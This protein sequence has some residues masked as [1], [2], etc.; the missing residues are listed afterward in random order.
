VATPLV[1]R[2]RRAQP[3]PPSAY[4]RSMS[5]RRRPASTA[6]GHPRATARCRL[7]RSGPGRPQ[8][9]GAR[10]GFGRLMPPGTATSGRR[11]AYGRPR[12]LAA[13][14]G[15]SRLRYPRI[16]LVVLGGR[17][18]E[19]TPVPRVVAHARAPRPACHAQESRPVNFDAIERVVR[20]RR[21]NLSAQ[22]E[23]HSKR[24]PSGRSGDRGAQRTQGIDDAQ[25][26]HSAMRRAVS[27]TRR[28][29]DIPLEEEDHRPK[30]APRPSQAPTAKRGATA[31]QPASP[32][33]RYPDA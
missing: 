13:A 26:A 9:Q 11:R 4:L 16:R 7:R 32:P 2:R 3:Q 33:A 6:V 23:L 12:A 15:F 1:D 20:Y 28:R 10:A 18:L 19:L 29:L 14:S 17:L 27:L 30:P 25:L 24:L 5:G 22:L 31:R 8:N 21:P